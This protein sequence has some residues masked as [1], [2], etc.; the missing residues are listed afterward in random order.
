MS[1]VKGQSSKTFVNY[2]SVFFVLLVGVLIGAKATTIYKNVLQVANNNTI[3]ATDI[4]STPPQVVIAYPTNKTRI[5]PNM[6]LTIT[7][8]A[9]DNVGVTYVEFR[10]SLL[11][12]AN[13]VNSGFLQ[14]P[15]R[16]EYI[17]LLQQCI[18]S[19]SP[20]SCSW[21]VPPTRNA[22]YLIQAVAYDA[23]GNQGIS[24]YIE[25]TVR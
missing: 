3:S 25:F 16:K 23:A 19:A 15:G 22:T 12:K 9:S 4:D 2:V 7:A 11:T 24:K 20:Y 13:S 8:N 6:V 1:N 14:I 5:S 10:V 21:T 17:Q 18:D